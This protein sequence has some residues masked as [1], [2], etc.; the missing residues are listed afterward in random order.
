MWIFLK[1]KHRF[2]PIFFLQFSS[3]GKNFS[4]FFSGIFFSIFLQFSSVGSIFGSRIFFAIFFAE[5][6]RSCWLNNF[7][8]LYNCITTNFDKVIK[9]KQMPIPKLANQSML[10]RTGRN[11]DHRVVIFKKQWKLEICKFQL[12]IQTLL[13]AL[14]PHNFLEIHLILILWSLSKASSYPF[15]YPFHSS[16]EISSTLQIL[17][18]KS[19]DFR[20]DSTITILFH[21]VWKLLQK[22]HFATLRA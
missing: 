19:P 1:R 7:W 3:I 14:R 12:K 22:S 6:L 18:F 17:Q 2:F 10:R 11:V 15:L 20:V 13:K 16:I 21:S 8:T 4:R 9:Q 5:I